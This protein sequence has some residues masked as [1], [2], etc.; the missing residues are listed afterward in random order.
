MHAP[1]F[2]ITEQVT[3]VVCHQHQEMGDSANEWL[4]CTLCKRPYNNDI[5]T[6]ITD[7]TDSHSTNVDEPLT[8]SRVIP[9]QSVACSHILCLSCVQQQ[10]SNLE[11]TTSN[12]ADGSRIIQCPR[13]GAKRAFDAENPI[14]ST[15]VCDLLNDLQTIAH[16]GKGI[17][18]SERIADESSDSRSDKPTA[19][20]QL[21]ERNAVLP[22]RLPGAFSVQGIIENRPETLDEELQVAEA[23]IIDEIP[24]V[25]A[26]ALV[27]QVTFCM[28]YRYLLITS[29]SIL[30]ILLFLVFLL[31]IVPR[32]IRENELLAIVLNVSN[33]TDVN[34]L[35]V[36]QTWAKNWILGLHNYGYDPARDREQIA[37]RYVFATLC[38]SLG[39]E[40]FTVSPAD[41]ECNWLPELLHCSSDGKASNLTFGK[42][43]CS[44]Y[45]QFVSHQLLAISLIHFSYQCA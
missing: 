40:N 17:N 35:G 19:V 31:V 34:G 9:V 20:S 15:I 45:F 7:T 6:A 38:W 4:Y 22:A 11:T 16:T 33:Q 21:S 39:C 25:H 36:P 29:F 2:A 18:D 8:L 14:V 24:T 32:Q 42:Q 27:Q 5:L 44:F 1:G 26:E 43:K 30:I 3:S 41:N 10:A 12:N 37:Q 13:C 23:R 28:R